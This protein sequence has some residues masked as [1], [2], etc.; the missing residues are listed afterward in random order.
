[1][2]RFCGDFFHREVFILHEFDAH[3]DP[4]C[5]I[6]YLHGKEQIGHNR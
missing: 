4:F 1:M 3:P 6:V 2:E 5:G